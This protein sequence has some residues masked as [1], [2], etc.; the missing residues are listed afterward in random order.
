MLLGAPDAA[1]EQR[2]R[3]AGFR[4]QAIAFSPFDTAA[5]AQISH[6][7]TYNRT[8]ASQRT[9]DIVAALDSHPGAALIATGDAALAGLLALAIVPNRTAIL[10]VGAFDTASDADYA[11]HLYMPGPRRAGGLQ[12]A[13]G[14]AGARLVLHNAGDRFSLAG[15]RIERTRLDEAAIV[16]ALG[17][18][19]R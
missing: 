3:S 13:A 2:L 14:L 4:V 15:V 5:A 18:G 7:E 11:A 9:A 12:T 19:R 10:N 8:A 6:F 17:A 1:L 16:A